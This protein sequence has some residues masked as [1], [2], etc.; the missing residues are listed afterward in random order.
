M[1]KKLGI[2]VL[3]LA[4]MLAFATPKPAEA[5]VH[6]GV[7]IGA[8][9]VYPYAYCSPYG[10]YCTSYAYPYGGAY[11]YYSYPYIYGGWGG[12]WHGHHDI[13]EHHEGHEFRGGHH[14]R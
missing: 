2:P 5:K 9:P 3:A 7:T 10:P 1:L 4:G 13:H 12:G 6:F 8:P 14:R 11:P